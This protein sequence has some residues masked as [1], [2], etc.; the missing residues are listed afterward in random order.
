MAAG[1][2]V[3]SLLYESTI[4]QCVL[5]RAAALYR[6]AHR[7]ILSGQAAV[8][9][10]CFLLVTHILFLF[11]DAPANRGVYRFVG[12]TIRSTARLRQLNFS[13]KS[14]APIDYHPISFSMFCTHRD[15]ERHRM[16]LLISGRPLGLT[17]SRTWWH[18]WITAASVSWMR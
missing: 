16:P 2:R 18:A 1:R 15:G 8:T 6:Q 17:L 7:L 3:R 11:R 14:M 9:D 10:Q 4:K 13:I 5:Y 12:V